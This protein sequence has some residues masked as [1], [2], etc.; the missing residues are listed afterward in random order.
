MQKVVR[1]KP[2]SYSAS[3]I[4]GRSKKILYNDVWLDSKWEYEFAK[5][6]DD[7]QINWEKNKKSFEY[8][9]NGSRL[10]YPD[11]YLKDFDKY[12]EVKGYERERDREKWKV[13]SNLI[14]IK[15]NEIKKI[16]SNTFSII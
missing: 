1:E 9:W 2:E 10:Y 3:N 11:F 8:N 7:N 4:N 15:F 13:V 14:I 16:R 12:V 6:C 5:W